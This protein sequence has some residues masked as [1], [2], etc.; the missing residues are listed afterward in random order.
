[1]AFLLGRYDSPPSL[2]S[3]TLDPYRPVVTG[4]GLLMNLMFASHLIYSI[5]QSLYKVSEGRNSGR[6]FEDIIKAS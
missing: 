5:R 3:P 4:V 2:T 1:M 6:R